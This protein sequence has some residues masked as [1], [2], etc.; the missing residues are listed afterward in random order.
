MAASVLKQDK[1][2]PKIPILCFV[3][4]AFFWTIYVW[5]FR[6]WLEPSF[7]TTHWVS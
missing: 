7:Q 3:L 6:I 1:V 4:I 2:T 5:I